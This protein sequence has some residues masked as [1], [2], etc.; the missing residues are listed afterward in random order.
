MEQSYYL[1]EYFLQMHKRLEWRLFQFCDE[2][3]DFVQNQ[4]WFDSFQPGLS[5]NCVSLQ[6]MDELDGVRYFA[7]R[8]GR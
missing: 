8:N 4:T 6:E 7:S 1:F 5:Q 3:V 2:A